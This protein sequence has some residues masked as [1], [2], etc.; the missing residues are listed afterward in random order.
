MLSLA[1]HVPKASLTKPRALGR[2]KAIQLLSDL[3]LSSVLTPCVL[4]MSRPHGKRDGP[5]SESVVA[6][7]SARQGRLG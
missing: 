2:D 5:D 6:Q 3:S 4:P 7:H 1:V